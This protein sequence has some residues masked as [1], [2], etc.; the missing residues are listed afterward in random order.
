MTSERS[1]LLV[2]YLPRFCNAIISPKDN[3]NVSP[4]GEGGREGP[5][6]RTCGILVSCSVPGVF[7]PL[8]SVCFRLQRA[9]DLTC[10]SEFVCPN[11]S[12]APSPLL[13]LSVL[14]W[15]RSD[16]DLKSGTEARRKIWVYEK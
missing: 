14:F 9:Q 5:G 3:K 8:S 2:F 7:F 16:G 12:K 1:E 15:L 11:P 13:P 4:L 6:H 10:H